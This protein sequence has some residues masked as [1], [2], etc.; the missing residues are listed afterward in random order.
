M[1][2][3]QHIYSDNA[4][5]QADSVIKIDGK[6]NPQAPISVNI[7]K[8]SNIAAHFETESNE[9]GEFSVEIK[10]PKASFDEY[11]IEFI[12]QNGDKY[13]INGVLF[14]EVW[15]AS[16]QSNMELPNCFQNGVNE[17]YNT[18]KEKNIRVYHV[19]YPEF[20]GNG[21]FPWMPDTMMTGRWI[22]PT[23]TD[24]LN[25][26]SAVALQF[27]D[28]IYDF[29]NVSASVPVAFLNATWGGTSMPSWFPYDAIE[30]DEYIKERLKKLN[31]YPTHENWN[32]RGDVNFQQ[33]CSQYNVKIAP[34]TGV[35]TRGVIWYQGEN[36]AGGEYYANIYADYLRFYHKTYAKRFGADPN[37][38]KMISSLIYPWTYGGSG[39]CNVG[40]L[41][42]AFVQTAI[43]A[44]DKFLAAPICDL[45]P[46]WAYAQGN[47]PIHPTNKYPLGERMA[48]LAIDNI[49]SSGSEQKMPAYMD[50]YEICGKR[51]RLHFE[52]V[53]EGIYLDGAEPVGLYVAGDD[54]IYLPAECEIIASDTIEIWCDA[55]SEPKNAAYSVQSLEPCCNIHAGK[56][57]V[58]PFFTD[59]EHYINIEAR[60]WY[61]TTR[62]AVWAWKGHDDVLDL[63]YHPIWHPEYNSEVCCDR[64]FSLKNQ[65]VRVCSD[66]ASF[67]CY[68]KSYPYNKLDLQ[69]FKKLT[70]NLYNTNELT[71]ALRLEGTNG[72]YEIPLIKC[73]DVG[74]GWSTYEAELGILPKDFE[75]IKMHF[76][77]LQKNSKYHFVN[78]EKVRLWK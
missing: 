50:K 2:Q 72:V 53:G 26:V 41:N 39:E 18:I 32:T 12:C 16:G 63:F 67:G 24:R 66:F 48:M 25:S 46:S 36:E 52:S 1:I 71:A 58:Y 9:N 21:N 65:S 75:I 13:V 17:L 34:L 60:P 68:V 33:T 74:A 62:T 19:D 73:Y 22:T 70:V 8:A 55:I 5:F 42:N 3:L 45:A 27:V 28:K 30:E 77:F 20:G 40:Y 10:T 38:F 76:I 61:D 47:H 59:K 7:L 31:N 14:G 35:K 11:S 64:A 43:E 29:I 49:Y 15:L 6:A 54:D 78:L 44:P 37:N 56:Y 69:K 23:E 4:V 57:P 51:M